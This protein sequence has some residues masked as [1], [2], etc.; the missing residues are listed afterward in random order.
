MLWQ[1]SDWDPLTGAANARGYEKI[2]IFDQCLAIS[3]RQY[4][5]IMAC[6]YE[7]LPKILNGTVT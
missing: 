6:E 7:T 4:Y 5:G 3:Q 2:A 1:Y